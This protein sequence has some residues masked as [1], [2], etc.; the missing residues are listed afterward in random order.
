MHACTRH[1]LKISDNVACNSLRFVQIPPHLLSP[2]LHV[3]C[4]RLPAQELVRGPVCMESEW[5]L[6][7]FMQSPQRGIRALHAEVTHL[8][9]TEL[10]KRALLL[11]SAEHGCLTPHEHQQRRSAP[12]ERATLRDPAAV[13]GVKPYF[14]MKGRRL[15]DSTAPPPPAAVTTA[16]GQQSS[17]NS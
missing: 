2:N 3:A 12:L 8:T 17:C 14:S 16:L 10:P 7:R 5:F 6:E 4:C 11:A 9:G 15:S 13:Q 1:I